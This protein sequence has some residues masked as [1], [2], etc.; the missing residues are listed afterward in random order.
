MDQFIYTNSTAANQQN[1]EGLLAQF[2]RNITKMAEED[3]LDPVL[4]RDEEITKVLKTLSR[5]K[6]NNALLIGDPGVGKSAIVEG[7]AQKIVNKDCSP[8]LHD[9]EIRLLDMT[10]IVAG[11][12]FRGEFEE[13]LTGIMEEVAKNPDIILFIDEIHTIV[14]AGSAAGT[15]DAANIIKPAL[16][17]GEFQCIG[18][19]TLDEYKK[20]FRT[21]KALDRRFQT[22]QIDEPSAEDTL[23]I[24]N[25]LKK[26]YELYHKVRYTD[27]AIQRAIE[28]S[29]KYINARFF[30]DKAIDLIDEAGAAKKVE[31]VIP[32]ELGKFEDRIEEEEE[33]MKAA[34][35]SENFKEAAKFRDSRNLLKDQ[36]RTQLDGWFQKLNNKVYEIT[37]EDIEKI[38]STN[39]G[40]PASQLN[41]SERKKLIELE[42]FLGSIVIGQDHAIEKIAKNIRRNR[43]GLRD[44]TKP[45]GSFLFTGPTGVGKTFLAKNIA[46]HIFGS[47]KNLIRVDMSDYQVKFDSGKLAGAAPGYVGYEEGGGLT[48]KVRNQ[49]YSVILLDEIE[50]AHP[51]IFNTFLQVLDDGI[52]TDNKGETVSFKNTVII[53]TS[54]L[55]I[56]KLQNFAKPVGFTNNSS[57]DEE[58]LKSEV[59]TKEMKKFFRPEFLNRLDDVVI[60]NYLTEENVFKIA[61]NAIDDLISRIERKGFKVKMHLKARKLIAEKGYDKLFGARPLNRVIANLVESPIT[62]TVLKEGYESGKITIK[63]KNEELDFKYEC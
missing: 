42:S 40:I 2:S 57:I 33:K 18:A 8:F 24:L 31:T 61:N 22:V 1:G 7:I 35:M 17:R 16:A 3:L 48:E 10:L 63:V 23:T 34:A 50:K 11:T 28:L 47:E 38:I 21:D 53:M 20:H 29:E 44:E 36:Y 41:K 49:P 32:A 15:M 58:A 30:P 4:C 19:T 25:T 56:A 27:A 26:H 52:L 39:T 62:D 43:F 60:F 51:D 45:I 55:G 13:R 6:K 37:A 54:N 14:G 9:K 59:I 5:R 46:K 12:K